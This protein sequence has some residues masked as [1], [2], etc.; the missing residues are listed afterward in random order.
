MT[1]CGEV[2]ERKHA[3]HY[4]TQVINPYFEQERVCSDALLD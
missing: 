3:T 2:L 4:S 1:G